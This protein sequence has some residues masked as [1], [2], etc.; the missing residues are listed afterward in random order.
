MGDFNGK[1]GK[2]QPNEKHVVGP[3]EISERKKTV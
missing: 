2:G 1:I 3:H